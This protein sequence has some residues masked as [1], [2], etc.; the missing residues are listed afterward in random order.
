MVLVVLS[1]AAVVMTLAARR[2]AQDVLAAGAAQSE[3]QVR[4]GMLSCRATV[5]PQADKLLADRRTPQDP[6]AAET[7]AYVLLGGTRFRLIIADELAKANVNLLALRDGDA[8]LALS[9]NRL[10]VTGQAG[11]SRLLPIELRPTPDPP[12]AGAGPPAR[13]GSFD[14]LFILHS[15]SEL[16]SPDDEAGDTARR[17]LTCWGAGVVNFKRA[18]AAVLAEILAPALSASNVARLDQYRRSHPGCTLGQAISSFPL[19][20]EQIQEVYRVV[21]EESDTFS[22]WVQAEGRT[23]SWYGFYVQRPGA[24]PDEPLTWTF[25]W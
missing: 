11:L 19:R 10:Q 3:L 6:V 9:L 7:E 8:G 24:T 23:R 13:Y 12:W 21:A 18:E 2:Y 22:L 17:R 20:R 15:P 5:L 25:T 4:W 1:V 14:Q 16:L